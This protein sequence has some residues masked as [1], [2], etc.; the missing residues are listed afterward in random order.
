LE[1]NGETFDLIVIGAGPGGYVAAI[2]AAEL[3]M[4]TACIERDVRPGGVCL[5]VGCIP[6]KALLESTEYYRFARD[7]LGRHAIRAREVSIDL[8]ALMERKEKIVSDLSDN[9]GKLME[10]SGVRLIRGSARLLS[11][12]EI[13]V[14]EPAQPVQ[15]R[16]CTAG[17]LLLAAGSEP[18]RLPFL[19]FDGELVVS[20]TDALKFES[21]PKSLGIIGGGYIGLELGSVWSRLGTEVTVIEVL[22]RIAL[23]LDGQVSR[24]LERLLRREGI[25]FRL[26]T[27]LTGAE[28]AKSGIKLL[29][30]S[31]GRRE[32]AEFDRVLVAVGRKPLTVG[33]GLDEIGVRLGP[34]GFVAVD[35]N[36]RTNVPGVYAIGDL[37][38]GPM[39][40]HKAS[41]EGRAAVER[42]AGLNTEVNY[43]AIPSVVYTSPEVA[44]VGKTEEELKRLGA[45]YTSAVYPFSGTGR[46]RCLGQTDGFVKLLAHSRSG[47]ILG[48]HIIGPRASELIAECVCAIGSR[49]GVK[50]LSDLIHAHPTLSEAVRESAAMLLNRK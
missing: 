15:P 6:S 38:P 12:T 44:S 46:A 27:K 37:I 28:K 21:V 45:D 23:A 34:G 36:Y 50:E 35:E 16:R 17:A 43:D 31:H 29:L 47:R 2:R 19:P 14:L 25:N 1:A 20:S 18:V 48:A 8:S 7:G 11:G 3:G 4:K 10:Q 32:E 13:E 5:N 39:L 24:L 22:P 30:D 26:E 41:A 33:L 49:A 42:M 40:A 9:V